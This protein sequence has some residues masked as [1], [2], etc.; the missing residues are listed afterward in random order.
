MSEK[1]QANEQLSSP[2]MINTEEE[3]KR[4]TNNLRQ[5]G[6]TPPHLCPPYL[7]H[8][9]YG[10]PRQFITT[11]ILRVPNVTPH[12][13]PLDAVL[14]VQRIQLPP[15]FGVFDRLF[16]RR[17]PAVFLPAPNPGRDAVLEVLGIC[18]E[19]YISI[20]TTYTKIIF[21]LGLW[22]SLEMSGERPR[23][24]EIRQGHEVS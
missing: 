8:S 15:Q 18:G 23:I 10:P 4:K 22:D 12:P 6:S 13:F 20:P 3:F 7:Y 9:R 16:V 11:L 19:L 5:R 21:A 24:Q 17:F 1:S 2:T 14:L